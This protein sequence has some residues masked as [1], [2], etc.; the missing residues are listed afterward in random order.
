[1]HKV[2][3]V[4]DDVTFAKIL[5]ANFQ[6]IDEFR[7][8][9]F[10][11]PR[12]LLDR[13]LE[14]PPD[15]VITDL[16]MPEMNGLQ[17][18]RELR[19]TDPHLPVL[20]L[21][22]HAEI[23]SAVEA[24][25][26]GATDYLTKPVNMKALL[27]VLRR[28]LEERPMRE[29]RKT[30]EQQ[31]KQA[32]SV[33][34]ILGSHPLV[35][36]VRT[37]VQRVAAVPNATVLLLGES[38]TGKNLVASA[39]HYSSESVGRRFV[40]VNCSA[41]PAQLLEAELFGYQKGA[42]TDARES[43]RGLIEVADGGTLFL[44]EIGELPLSLQS[45]LLGFLES[46]RFRRV[47]GTEEIEVSLRLITATNRDLYEGMNRGEFRSDLYFRIG[48]ATHTLPPLRSIRQDIPVL[49]EHFLDRFNR[50][51][52]KN[53]RGIS[54]EARKILLGW[55]WPGNVRELRNVIERAMIF[56]DGSTLRPVDLPPLQSARAQT[57]VPTA[58]RG[59]S[60]EAAE[61]EHI[62]HVLA[63]TGGNIQKAAEILGISRKNLW[64]KRKKHGLLD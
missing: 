36:E 44:D 22:A 28:A 17:L 59:L 53:V 12:E 2:F 20:V 32:F 11:S 50:E 63:E 57:A 54:V 10:H 34:S 39:I 1:M 42:F 46:R 38:G 45:K 8:E 13:K 43:K 61:R 30:L 21:T 48:V 14:D 35:E 33:H 41:V 37:F 3:I 56:A 52:K 18:T 27:A 40:E 49:A 15:V 24:L 9:V 4:D 7:V 60:L 47:G 51:F 6:R 55:D 29:E 16:V 25:R 5:A 31:R 19:R 23:E 26:V 62:R 64:E 58:S